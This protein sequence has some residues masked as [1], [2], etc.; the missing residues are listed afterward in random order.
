M[1][2]YADNNS[3][4]SSALYHVRRRRLYRI[5]IKQEKYQTSQ[6][7]YD[8]ENE[9]TTDTESKSQ[10]NNT[11]EF[12]SIFYNQRKVFKWARN[13]LLLNDPKVYTDESGEIN[14]PF[15]EMN[16]IPPRPG[17]TWVPDSTWTIDFE[18]TKTDDKGWVYG[19][20]FLLLLLHL[21]LLSLLLL[22]ILSLIAKLLL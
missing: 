11:K 18:Y 20:Y 4:S 7:N 3:A 9:K 1:R 16:D 19:Y 8:T 12:F 15:E 6:S 17:Y 2:R 21:L 5:A 14:Y 10:T 22:Q 13:Q